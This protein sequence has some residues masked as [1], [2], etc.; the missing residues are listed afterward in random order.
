LDLNF[1]AIIH[2]CY[3]HNFYSKVLF[4]SE[5]NKTHKKSQLINYLAHSN[6]LLGNISDGIKL[7]IGPWHHSMKPQVWQL[8]LQWTKATTTSHS[9]NTFSTN[10][11]SYFSLFQFD[12]ILSLS[13]Q[14][15]EK[16]LNLQSKLSTYFL[17]S[18]H[19]NRSQQST[20]FSRTPPNSIENVIFRSLY[21]FSMGKYSNAKEDIHLA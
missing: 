11:Q 9:Q 1:L 20:F 21:L 14:L 3:H 15:F 13:N 2:C 8:L 17:F 19:L 10:I 18:E 5:F 12:K 4:F 6:A 16:P 7:V